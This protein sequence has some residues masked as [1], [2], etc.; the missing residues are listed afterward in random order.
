MSHQPLSDIVSKFQQ[1]GF[2][3]VRSLLNTKELA[4]LDE[5]INCYMESGAMD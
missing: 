5:H 2:A 3:I 1:D 4:D